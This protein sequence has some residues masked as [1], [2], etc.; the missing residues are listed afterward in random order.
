MRNI[1]SKNT[2][3]SYDWTAEE[4]SV[5]I[6]LQVSRVLLFGKQPMSFAAGVRCRGDGPTE[7]CS[8]AAF[9]Q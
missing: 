1:F 5:P 7:G 3:S 9:A 6:H 4:C 2:E 8:I